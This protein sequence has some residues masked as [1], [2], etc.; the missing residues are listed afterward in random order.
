[1]LDVDEATSGGGM[2]H[3]AR[4]VTLDPAIPAWLARIQAEFCESPGLRLTVAQESVGVL[5][6][7]VVAAR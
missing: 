1:M 4:D 6:P 5:A 2:K 3:G 7:G